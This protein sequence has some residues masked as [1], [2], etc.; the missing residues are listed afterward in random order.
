MSL[1]KLKRV[2][3]GFRSCTNLQHCNSRGDR[4][5]RDEW[6]HNVECPGS[7]ESNLTEFKRFVAGQEHLLQSVMSE[8][9][10]TIT[11]ILVPPV[12]VTSGPQI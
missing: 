2:K 9:R 12:E 11:A 7:D 6:R 8:L 1:G 3:R 10:R 5:A 4:G